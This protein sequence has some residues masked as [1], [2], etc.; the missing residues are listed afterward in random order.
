MTGLY[1]PPVLPFQTIISV[2]VHTAVPPK[3]GA[4]VV[5]MLLQ[6]SVLGLYLAAFSPHTII[7]V[8]VHILGPPLVGAPV[9]LVAYQLSVPGL[10][11]PPVFKY[12]NP[13]G[14]QNPPPQTIIS[15]PVH[16]AVWDSRKKG[17]FT[18]VVAVQLSRLGLYLP[19]VFK[20]RT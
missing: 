6:L 5:L 19:P 10:Y 3:G 8:P 17:A 4:P 18:V 20:S 13:S 1:L 11:L 7:S 9:V 12:W 14:D 16:T 2:P 15:V